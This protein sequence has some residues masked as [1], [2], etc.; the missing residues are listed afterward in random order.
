MSDHY[1]T[2]TPG[3]DHD[4]KTWSYV[5]RGHSFLFTTDR[6]VFSKREVDYGSRFLI[7]SYSSP[8]VAGDVL[9]VGCGYGPIGLA[10]ARVEQGR[11]VEM[12]DVNERAC[13]LAA[14]NAKQNQIDNVVVRHVDGA[15]DVIK[16]D[17]AAIVT[18]PP[19]RAGKKVVFSIY[20][21]AHDRLLTGGMLWV[22]IQKKQGAASTKEKLQ[23][24]FGKESVETIAKDKGYVLFCAKKDLTNA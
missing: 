1:Y 21:E 24:L 5:L 17:F 10:I 15:Q 12:I 7:E 22:V 11:M 23:V 20:E 19:I 18:N 3:V 16:R 14:R 8:D 13:A 4:E 2:R 9:D 6:G